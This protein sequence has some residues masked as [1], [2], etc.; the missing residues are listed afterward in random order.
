MSPIV[1]RKF[2]WKPDPKSEKDIPATTRLQA[3][4]AAAATAVLPAA[5]CLK[6]LIT[7]ILDQGGLGSCTANAVAQALRAALVHAG[8]LDPE[9]ASRLFLYY[10]ARAAGGDSTQSD[11][12]AYIRANFD[13]LR[14]LGVAREAVWTYDDTT[15]DSLTGPAKFKRMPPN[16]AIRDAY[17][18]KVSVGYYRID[19]EGEQRLTDIMTALAGGHLVVFGTTVTEKFG[20]PGTVALTRPTSDEKV[21]GGHALTI[22]GYRWVAGRRVF[23]IVNSWGPDYNG[24][25]YCEMDE[26]YITWSASRDFWIVEAF[27]NFSPRS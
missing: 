22:P 4:R 5:V 15:V 27:P 26:S 1:D 18:Q 16:E 21:L 24:T 6:N 9:L 25:G 19:S 20:S 11:T 17:E 2:C 13:I 3:L 23:L 8:V 7:S 14:R 10:F 12:G